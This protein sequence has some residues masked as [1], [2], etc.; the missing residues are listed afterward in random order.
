MLQGQQ[1][2]SDLYDWVHV[3]IKKTD[4]LTSKGDKREKLYTTMTGRERGSG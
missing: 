4:N 3:Y 1:A 2:N